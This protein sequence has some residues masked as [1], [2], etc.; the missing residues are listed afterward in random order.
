MASIIQ[1]AVRLLYSRRAAPVRVCRAVLA[2]LGTR[3]RIHCAVLAANA[4]MG[5]V[6]VVDPD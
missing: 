5:S 2:L 1:G 6:K 3:R 4:F